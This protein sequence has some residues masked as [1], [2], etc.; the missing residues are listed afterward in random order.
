VTAT[1]FCAR[2]S[3]VSDRVRVPVNRHTMITLARPSMAESSPKPS[4]A[5]DPAMTAAMMAMAP[6]ADM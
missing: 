6:S 5:T 2:A 1:A 3:A 4:S